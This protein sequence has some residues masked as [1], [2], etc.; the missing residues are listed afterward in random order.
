MARRTNLRQIQPQN[1]PQTRKSLH[2][3]RQINHN[4]LMFR[5][6]LLM[7]FVCL[8]AFAADKPDIGSGGDLPFNIEAKQSLEY[9]QE[10]RQYVA[11]GAA[12]VTRGD[13]SVTGDT[14]TAYERDKAGNEGTEVYKFTADGHVIVSNGKAVAYGDKADYNI[15]SQMAVLTGK[16]LKL[17]AE[18]DTLT[19]RDRF[20]YYS[21][22]QKAVAIGNAKAIRKTPEGTRTITADRMTAYFKKDKDGKTV[23]DR[24]EAEGNVKMLTGTDVATGNSGTYN[25]ATSKATLKGDV[26]LTRGPNQLEGDAAEVDTETG[27]SKL[28]G[29]ENATSNKS[30]VRGLLVPGSNDMNKTKSE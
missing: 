7:A 17:I 8:P 6:A 13:F 20:E 27:V 28:L 23:A 3:Q 2:S 26:R 15:D 29:T 22:D 18:A 11:R 16:D 12:K 9:Q 4:Y 24:I 1:R 25:P 5:A 30:R 19:A 14:L 10:Q 21:A